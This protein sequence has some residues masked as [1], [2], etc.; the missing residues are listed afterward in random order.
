MASLDWIDAFLVT[1]LFELMMAREADSSTALRPDLAIPHIIVEGTGAFG[2]LLARCRD[3]IHFSELAPKR[4]AGREP[5]APQL[6]GRRLL[7]GAK[8]ELGGEGGEQVALHQR[9]GPGHEGQI[10]GVFGFG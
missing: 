7:G 8:G 2:L 1:A 5:N 4:R 9:G 10:D 3:G 6:E